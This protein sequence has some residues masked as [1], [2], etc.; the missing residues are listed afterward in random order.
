M[1][2]PGRMRIIEGKNHTLVLD[3]TYNSS[4]VAVQQA[5]Q[6]V[7]DLTGV[8]KK[9][10][11][12]GDM[13]ELGR[14][15]VREHE[16]IGEQVATSADVLMTLGVR[17]RKIA[18]GA[19]ENGMNEKV[20]LQYDDIDRAGKELLEIMEPGDVILIKASQGMRA[21]KLVARIMEHPD[22]AKDMLCRQSKVW[23]RK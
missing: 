18:E 10:V 6:T 3:D 20:I 12:L 13:L 23:L 22:Q 2:P 16:R 15:S 7:K 4:P 9:I 19:L 1:P 8:G 5:L 21:E 17:S 11:V 14:Y